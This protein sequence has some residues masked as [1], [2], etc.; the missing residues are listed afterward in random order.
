MP[1]L[2]LPWGLGNFWNTKN[3]SLKKISNIDIIKEGVWYNLS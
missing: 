3:S 1:A 2:N